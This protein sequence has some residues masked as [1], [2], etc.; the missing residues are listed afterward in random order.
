MKYAALSKQATKKSRWTPSVPGQGKFS[1]STQ[2]PER[3]ACTRYANHRSHPLGLRAAGRMPEKPT[4]ERRDFVLVYSQVDQAVPGMAQSPV[5]EI[6]VASEKGR[7]ALLEQER[8]DLVILH[9]APTHVQTD[10]AHRDTPQLQE[11]T[12]VRRDVLVQDV[13]AGTGSNTNSL[14]CRSRASRASCTAS[15]IA[16]CVR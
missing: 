2:T 15:R 14:E 11:L 10:L 8:G 4:D 12:L 5:M 6:F 13:H 9:S 16:S 3:Q 1:G 7:P